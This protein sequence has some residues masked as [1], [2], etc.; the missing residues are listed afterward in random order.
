[1]AGKI[2]EYLTGSSHELGRAGSDLTS[3][4][5]LPPL[6]VD[7]LGDTT[8]ETV[9][10]GSHLTLT[11]VGESRNTKIKERLLV[12]LIVDKEGESRLST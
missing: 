5:I 1:M 3:T 9:I 4:A 11:T 12:L 10:S 6:K 7:F 2:T 8:L